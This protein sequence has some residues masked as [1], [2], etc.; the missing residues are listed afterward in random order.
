MW[1]FFMM[2]FS[3]DILWRFFMVMF[4]GDFWWRFYGDVLW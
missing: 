2:I 1:G 4:Y 3:G